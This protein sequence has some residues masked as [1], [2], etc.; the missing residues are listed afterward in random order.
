V[1]L[2]AVAALVLFAALSTAVAHALAEASRAKLDDMLENHKRERMDRLLERHDELAIAAGIFRTALETA[3]VVGLAVAPALEHASGWAVFGWAILLVLVLCELIPRLL[4]ERSPERALCILLSSYRFLAMPAMPL[5]AGLLGLARLVRSTGE[6]PIEEEDEAAED[7]L[8][9]VTEGEKEGS[10]GGE[11]ADMIER[12]VELHDVDVAEIMTPRTEM[13]SVSVDARLEE[14]VQALLASGR[15]RVPVFRNTRDDIIGVLYVRDVLAA[16]AS[17]KEP[18][19]ALSTEK[20]MRPADFVPETMPISD[21][22]RHF[23]GRGTT[24]AIVV[25]EYG[26]TAGLV[27]ISDILDMIVGE[28]REEHEPQRELLVAAIDEHTLEADARVPVRVLNDNYGATI[29]ESD[30]Y[31]TVA[32][33]LCS[34]LGRVPR[35]GDHHVAEDVEL[36]VLEASERR[37]QSV[38]ITVKGGIRRD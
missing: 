16:L 23:Q 3:A 4:V 21:L 28:V 31:D 8:S 11:Q 29:P 36:V 38:R 26:G 9:A 30:A 7:I 13:T 10:I 15:S 5:A 2:I 1:T 22:L 20:L 25:D 18:R 27:S 34:V 33:Y 37:V 35:P 32:G 12:I 17:G 24:M 19:E 6:Q 14:T